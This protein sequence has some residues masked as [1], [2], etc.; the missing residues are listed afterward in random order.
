MQLQGVETVPADAISGRANL[1]VREGVTEPPNYLTESELI[2]IMERN[3]IGTDASIPTHIENVLKRNYVTLVAG[4]RLQAIQP[5]RGAG[6]GLHAYR[7]DPRAAGRAGRHRGPVRAHRGGRR[8]ARGRRH[9]R[10]RHLREQV[11]QLCRQHREDGHALRR[12]F[13]KLEDAGRPFTRCGLTRRF[14][15]YIEGPPCRLYNKFTET[16]YPLP[17]GGANEQWSGQVCKAAGC[18][19]E[20]LTYTVGS[21]RAPFRSARTATTTRARNGGKRRRSRRRPARQPSRRQPRQPAMAA[22]AL[23]VAPMGDAW[24]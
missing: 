21:R 22:A 20:M 19:F 13:A 9:H 6:A 15:T 10:A 24:F 17:A 11:P 7:P 8:R 5:R 3:N 14:M 12:D 2:S 1:S 18:T 16:I 4:R 23:A